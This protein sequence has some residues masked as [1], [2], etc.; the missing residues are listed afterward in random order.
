MHPVGVR[1]SRVPTGISTSTIASWCRFEFGLQ[2]ETAEKV[3]MKIIP[4]KTFLIGSII[5]TF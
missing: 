5:V 2:D 4:K 3:D 1:S